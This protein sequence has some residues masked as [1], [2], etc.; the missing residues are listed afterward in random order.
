MTLVLADI[1]A[2]VD[3][4]GRMYG[5]GVVGGE[6]DHAHPLE[7][8]LVVG[9]SENGAQFTECLGRQVEAQFLPYLA[10]DRLRMG[11]A[12]VT[13]AA[14]EIEQ[15]AASGPDCE[16]PVAAD[17]DPC[18]DVEL[19]ASMVPKIGQGAPV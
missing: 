17:V 19:H 3:L 18:H 8:R 6:A 7:Q 16:Q 10:G 15:V 14:G 13:F 12:R 2:F 4:G 5:A 1:E 9:G 11:L